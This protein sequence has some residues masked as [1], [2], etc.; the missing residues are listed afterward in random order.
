MALLP[1]PDGSA[2]TVRPDETEEQAWFRA[3][4]M[5]PEAFGIKQNHG[6]MGAI[7]HGA[8][9]YIADTAEAGAEIP[10]LG[11]L[12]GWAQDTMKEDQTPGA[13]RP[14]T[15]ADAD[16]ETG[17]AWL[18]AK[19]NQTVEPVGDTI[20]SLGIP[21]AGG[22]AAGAVA[23]PGAVFTAPAAITA[24]SAPAEYTKNMR[25]QRLANEERTAQGQALVPEDKTTAMATSILQ[26]AMMSGAGLL[27]KL[28]PRVMGLVGPELGALT[29]QVSRGEIT[30]EAAI[31]QVNSKLRDYVGST[32]GAAVGGTEMMVGTDALRRAQA[33]QEV[34]S[35][36][37]LGGYWEDIKNAGVLAPV[38]GLH[39]AMRRSGQIKAIEGSANQFESTWDDA[40]KMNDTENTRRTGSETGTLFD[41]PTQPATS[42]TASELTARKINEQ[43]TE[44]AR[45][46][47]EENLGP[48]QDNYYTPEQQR[49]TLQYLEDSGATPEQIAAKQQEMD[50]NNA[51]PTPKEVASSV[52]TL[53][54]AFFDHL[55]IPKQSSI[56]TEYADLPIT[57]PK[58]ASLHNVLLERA[59]KTKDPE[60]VKRMQYG[61]DY[62]KPDLTPDLT[63]KKQ[64]GFEFK[65]PE[66]YA[67]QDYHD[68]FSGLLD[69]KAQKEE[70]ANQAARRDMAAPTGLGGL[71][72]AANRARHLGDRPDPTS[73]HAPTGFGELAAKEAAATKAI[74]ENKA[75][76]QQIAEAEAKRQQAAELRARI[77]ETDAR[78]AEAEPA[79]QAAMQ[80]PYAEPSAPITPMKVD[81]LAIAQKHIDMG[82]RVDGNI[83]RNKD[84]K[85]VFTLGRGEAEA[86]A[87][88]AKRPEPG[89]QERPLENTTEDMFNGQRTAKDMS[90]PTR[91]PTR[92]R[93]EFNARNE[94][95]YSEFQKANEHY[96]ETGNDTA[97]TKVLAR[98]KEELT[99]LND[100]RNRVSTRKMFDTKG[101]PT[102]G[103]LNH[104]RVINEQR[105]SRAS[106]AV[107]VRESKTAPAKRDRAVTKR[108][109]NRAPDTARAD[110]GEKPVKRPLKAE[111]K[112]VPE[113]KAKPTLDANDALATA[114]MNKI[115][116]TKKSK[117][118]VSL[119][120]EKDK[121]QAEMLSMKGILD[122]ASNARRRE[123]RD[124]LAAIEKEKQARTVVKPQAEA[125]K[126]VEEL[127]SKA[128][129]WTDILP[130]KAERAA[131]KEARPFSEDVPPGEKVTIEHE[132]A[133][134]NV[135]ESAV[136][137]KK[138]M[139]AAEQASKKLAKLEEE[140]KKC[141]GG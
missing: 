99:P 104:E 19:V 57:D 30:K 85:K 95:L 24:L 20:G 101:K 28:T 126:D 31:A 2:V 17:L 136:P 48:L 133:N 11:G 77:A 78:V 74:A 4:R 73:I 36:E 12:K 33:Q 91:E 32:V 88:R 61:M 131:E 118:Q 98:A 109:E 15:Q 125:A 103:A 87:G 22:I 55:K 112:V 92:N 59:E 121:L 115:K 23:G 119:A 46:Y 67:H 105:S 21:I 52:P 29:N 50:A 39:G 134:G 72:A 64:T 96:Q 132:D 68:M 84:G 44:P 79:R 1:L 106:D 75:R 37:A 58:V 93:E 114:L 9:Q 16:K 108:V 35:P 47:T 113:T 141:S 110:V 8:A 63:L 80:E 25:Q 129:S 116:A 43:G 122:T 26:G 70:L 111:T 89:R 42:A 38:L 140:F 137:A 56:R 65:S 45:S 40:H 54:K 102:E 34:A 135:V 18:G 127:A 124:R 128:S 107:P 139:R 94:E 97:L 62:I 83:I 7:K 90:E 138:Q 41:D 27:G 86:L 14:T 53:D 49:D 100:A 82:G 81:R 120:S 3:Q 76:Q 123:I 6:I 5:Y 130:T 51:R 10:G 13:W 69:E 71:D 66:E 117:E 60:V